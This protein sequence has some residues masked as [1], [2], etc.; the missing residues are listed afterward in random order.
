MATIDTDTGE[1]TQPVTTFDTWLDPVRTNMLALTSFLN[2]LPNQTLVLVGVSDDAGLT[3]W[4]SCEHYTDPTTE[5]ARQA[6]E[7][8]GATMIRSYCYRGSWS[9]ISIKGAGPQDEQLS[10]NTPAISSVTL[11]F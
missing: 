10:P 3:R 9:L 4:D 11:E 1:L 2:G 7:A 8:I 6:L 5:N